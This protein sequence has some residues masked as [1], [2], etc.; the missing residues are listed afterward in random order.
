MKQTCRTSYRA[1]E[2]C[3]R[4]RAHQAFGARGS[5]CLA[6]ADGDD[7]DRHDVL[8]SHRNTPGEAV[9]RFSEFFALRTSARRDQSGRQCVLSSS[10]LMVFTSRS[11]R[12]N[13]NTFPVDG[14]TLTAVFF[15]MLLPQLP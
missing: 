7:T 9:N 6:R 14:L 12:A 1:Y 8:E 3:H 4:D 5:G 2:R 15:A 10:L 11:D 13:R